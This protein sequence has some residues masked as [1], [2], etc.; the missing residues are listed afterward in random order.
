VIATNID[1]AEKSFQ[2]IYTSMST[3][4]LSHHQPAAIKTSPTII[5]MMP[6]VLE[7]RGSR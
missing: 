7:I 6:G 2:S 1:T 3:I 5:E 4:F